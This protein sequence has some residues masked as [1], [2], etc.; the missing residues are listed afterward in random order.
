MNDLLHSAHTVWPF[1]DRMMPELKKRVV[2]PDRALGG[3]VLRLEDD[4]TI[5]RLG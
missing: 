5:S 3:F 1:R 4:E 2:N